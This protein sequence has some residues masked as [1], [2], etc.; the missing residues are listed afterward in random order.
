MSV[1]RRL[2]QKGIGTP[3]K[4]RGIWDL[5]L[6]TPSSLTVETSTKRKPTER[7]KYIL[8]Y[9]FHLSQTLLSQT[10]SS[11]F[12]RLLIP[13]HYLTTLQPPSH[14][15]LPQHKQF[16]IL[17]TTAHPIP[18]PRRS[19]HTRR[20]RKCPLRPHLHNVLNLK[21]DFEGDDIENAGIRFLDGVGADARGEVLGV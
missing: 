12:G 21:L 8:H 7:S 5:R 17:L 6:R 1:I 15:L 13:K 3:Y 9:P 10:L 16:L 20:P 18:H 19:P 2:N 11:C 14:P 4:E